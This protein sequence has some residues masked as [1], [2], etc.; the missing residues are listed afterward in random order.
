[1]IERYARKEA[2]GIFSLSSRYA[3]WQRIEAACLEAMEELG[4]VPSGA[5]SELRAVSIDVQEILEI[6]KERGHDVIAFIEY[7]AARM[8]THGRF[9]HY[10]MTSSDVVDSAFACQLLDALDLVLSGATRAFDSLRR[11][12]LEHKDTVM[13]G[14]T[15][16]VHAEPY[17]FGLK[18]LS[19][20]KELER[21]IGRLEEAREQLAY[22]KIS[23]AVGTYAHLPPEVEARAL[24]KVGLK[25]E[26]LS[27]QVVP[28][29]RHAHLFLQLALLAA[30][31][32]RIVLE[33]RHLQRTEVLE[34]EEPFGRSQRGSSAMPHK[35]N[36]ILCENLCGLARLMR[37]Y[38]GP[39]LEDVALWHERDISHSS[40]E[41][42]IGEDALVLADFMLHRLA[43]ILD[44]LIVHKGRML[45]NLEA[46]G[47]MVYSQ[48]ILLALTE[49]GMTRTKAYEAVQKAALDAFS[50]GGSFKERIAQDQN[51]REVLSDKELEGLFSW[52]PYLK[53]V[54]TVY[55]RCLG[56][57]IQD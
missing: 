46:L 10:G 8:P 31:I 11:L 29:D 50:E 20:Y 5:A 41:R 19:W 3:Y 18:V 28:R 47:G 7:A 56:P 36:P 13:V 48:R 57:S 49:R 30:G 38:V 33:I 42:V 54:D 39:A 27:T 26:P 22:G 6:E 34:L 15:H 53:H 17:S 44:G 1:M 55:E 40:V 37:S 16:G 24:K 51:V 23:G 12:A 9:L 35:K 14:R 43:F 25:P 52:G 45:H 21:N 2:S 32:E 4:V